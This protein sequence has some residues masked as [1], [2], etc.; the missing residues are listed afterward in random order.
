MTLLLFPK[1]VSEQTFDCT[2]D[3]IQFW[4]EYYNSIMIDSA[5]KKDQYTLN[6]II[7]LRKF[8]LGY[9]GEF[10]F[11]KKCFCLMNSTY[12]RTYDYSRRIKSEEVIRYGTGTVPYRWYNIFLREFSLF[13]GMIFFRD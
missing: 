4:Y 9:S 1:T 11:L 6:I 5:K 10:G 12:V 8:H 13:F 3:S 7:L 2:V